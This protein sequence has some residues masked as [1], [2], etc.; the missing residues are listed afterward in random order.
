MNCPRNAWACLAALLLAFACLTAAVEGVFAEDDPAA[1]PTTD[2]PY[3]KLA[4]GVM[5]SVDPR[6]DLGETTSR[7][8]VIELLAV[9]ANLDFAKDVPFR[10]DV[11]TLEFK[12]KPVRMIWIDIPQPSGYMQ[13]K[14]LWYMVYSVTN[15]GKTLHPVKELEL[16]YDTNKEELLYEVQSTEQPI[17]FIPEFVLEGHQYMKDDTGF[18]KAYPDR[19]I[20][21]AIGPISRREDPERKFYNAVDIS[22][23]EIDVGETLW[24]IATWEDVDPRIVRFS[25]FVYG[26]TNAYKWKDPKGEYK[27]GDEVGAG[28]KLYRKVLKLNFWRPSDQYFEHEEEIR[29]GVPGG[30]DYRWVYR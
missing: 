24:G 22:A 4:P 26:L 1:P 27:A 21:V 9:D 20:P 5:K 3:R 2:S 6:Q 10:H 8:D 28:R 18:T 29:Y 23:R 11:W 14:L 7:H 30:V 25:V 12:F 16:P 19:V 15:T 13:R 17:R